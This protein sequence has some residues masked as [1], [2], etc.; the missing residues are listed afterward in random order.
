MLVAPEPVKSAMGAELVV[1]TLV[2]LL[3][4]VCA[5]YK[6]T[7]YFK[8]HFK[9]RCISYRYTVQYL[10]RNIIKNTHFSFIST[11]YELPG[12]SNIIA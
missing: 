3:K 6:Y 2:A 10:R 7:V 9:G 12:Q 8:F 1:S 11:F 4:L 5:L